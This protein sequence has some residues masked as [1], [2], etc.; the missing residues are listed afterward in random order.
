MEMLLDGG[1]QV[2]NL[3]LVK[4]AENGIATASQEARNCR[5]YR[6]GVRWPAKLQIYYALLQVNLPVPGVFFS[7]L[8]E[9]CW[10][11]DRLFY[12]PERHYSGW[13]GNI[14][15]FPGLWFATVCKVVR[16]RSTAEFSIYFRR[17]KRI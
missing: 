4:Q 10:F 11:I 3:Y 17:K 13:S 12:E 14:S 15:D 2:N 8:S 16:H 5:F 6:E 9:L 7:C 1:L